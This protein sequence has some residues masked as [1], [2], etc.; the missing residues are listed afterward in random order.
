MAD[1]ISVIIPAYNVDGFIGEAFASVA[2]QTQSVHEILVVNDGSTDR[3]AAWLRDMARKDARLRVLTSNRLGPSGA[4]NVG[5]K[6]ATRS[7][8]AFLD[9]DD[10]WPRQKIER[11]MDRLSAP[12][13]PDI[14][15]GLIRRFRRLKS[16]SL[17][18]DGEPGEVMANVNLGASLF[19]RRAFDAIGRFDERLFHCEDL[20]L[21]FRAREVGLKVAIMREVTLYYRI[22]PGSWTQTK[23]SERENELGALAALRLSIGR[24][25]SAGRTLAL[26]PFATLIDE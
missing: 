26:P 18:P 8:I 13:R 20:D 6:A 19:R 24:R 23:S 22:R 15:S 1:G 16:G 14:V 21:M 12:D 3:T 2:A 17:T 7:I 11:Q 4:R 9:A 25:R 10:V 5:L